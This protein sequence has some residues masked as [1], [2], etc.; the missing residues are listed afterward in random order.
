MSK[1][2]CKDQ[3]GEVVMTSKLMRIL[4]EMTEE[5]RIDLLGPE[6]CKKQCFDCMAI[7]GERQIKTKQLINK[8]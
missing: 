5:E 1:F 7:V 3:K 4:E 8:K 6:P 2:Y